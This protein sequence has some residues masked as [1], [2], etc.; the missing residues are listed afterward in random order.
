MDSIT[1][2]RFSLFKRLRIELVIIVSVSYY[3]L[4]IIYSPLFKSSLFLF[5]KLYNF[6]QNVKA[7]KV[8]FVLRLFRYKSFAF[9]SYS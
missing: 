7:R 3:I 5:Y 2:E 8:A 4:I 9:T 6:T 1:R